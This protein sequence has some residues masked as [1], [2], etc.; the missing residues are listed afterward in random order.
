VARFAAWVHEGDG[1]M[2][3][4][5]ERRAY[6]LDEATR[7]MGMALDEVRL[8]RPAIELG[9]PDWLECMRILGL[10][11][12]LLA[13]A[14]HAAFHVLVGRLDGVGAA[15]A[16]A[17][18]H[19]GDCGIY[20]VTTVEAARRRGLGTALT[21]L[22]VHDARDRGCRTASLQSTAMAEAMYAAVGFRDLGRYLEFVRAPS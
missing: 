4:E 17:Y 5:L 2:R 22:H 8:P 14:D 3:G 15:A 21:A 10:P 12:G 18:D 1:P 9:P 16:M 7:A 13:G 6:S 19:D 11:P 20:N